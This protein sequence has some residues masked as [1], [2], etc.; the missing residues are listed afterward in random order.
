MPVFGTSAATFNDNGVTALYQHLAGLLAGHGLHLAEGVLP[1]AAGRTSTGAAPI[2]PPARTGYLAE[3][4]ETVRDYHAETGRQGA[5]ARRLQ[6]LTDVAAELGPGKRSSGTGRGRRRRRRGRNVGSAEAVAALAERAGGRQRRAPGSSS[7]GRPWWRRTRV[8]EQVV[9]IRDRELRT[10][11]TRET[12]SGTV[13]PRVALPRYADH[14]EL[15]RFLREE[16]LPGCFPFTAGVFAFKREGE[17]PARMFAGEGD[18]FR[19]N[20]RFHLLADGRRG[21][22]AFDRL[23]QRDPLRA[24]PRLSARRLRQGRRA[25]VSIARSTT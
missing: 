12:L 21:Q 22:A 5:A 11:L 14:G 4:A 23:R 2:I 20:R 17:D 9:R 10:E 7:A 19:T 25:G 16:N 1:A 6:Q 13:V 18:P 24:R 3:I 8:T 15:L